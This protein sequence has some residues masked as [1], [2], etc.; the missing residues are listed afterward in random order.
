MQISNG[1]NSFNIYNR[2]FHFT[3]EK[4]INQS[5]QST[6]FVILNFFRIYLYSNDRNN[7]VNALYNIS[8]FNYTELT[9]LGKVRQNKPLGLVSYSTVFQSSK[10]KTRENIPFKSI[11][12]NIF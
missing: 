8:N 12:I 4:E 5:C 2:K 7:T 10:S 6:K 9:P 3:V 1:N 11:Q